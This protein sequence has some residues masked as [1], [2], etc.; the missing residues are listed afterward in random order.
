MKYL[1]FYRE[2]IVITNTN[3]YEITDFACKLYANSKWKMPCTFSLPN[4][5]K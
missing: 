3:N 1:K 2:K 5:Y 4:E